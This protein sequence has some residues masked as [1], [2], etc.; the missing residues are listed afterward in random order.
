MGQGAVTVH[1]KDI[2]EDG[3]VL[4]IWEEARGCWE[5]VCAVAGEGY[6]VDRDDG[7]VVWVGRGVGGLV[8][9][10]VGHL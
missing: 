8:G 5:V 6:E 9:R 4:G 1:V 2:A 3:Q 7:R 10:L